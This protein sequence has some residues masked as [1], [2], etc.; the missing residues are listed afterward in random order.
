MEIYLMN[1]STETEVKTETKEMAKYSVKEEDWKVKKKN[2]Y[3]ES[4]IYIFL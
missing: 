2:K 3:V 1:T 4:A